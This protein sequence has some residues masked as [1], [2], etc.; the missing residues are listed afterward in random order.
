[1]S[2][3][4]INI[5]RKQA[6]CFAAFLVLYEFLTYIANDMIMPGM[7]RVVHA[8][9]SD[10]SAVATSL[11]A[12]VLGGASLQLLLGPLSDRFGRRPVMLAGAT[13]FLFFTLFIA[14]S[15][16]MNQFL[17]ARFFEGMGLCFIGVIGYATLQEIFAEMDAIRLVAVLSNVATLA[18]LLGPLAGAAC[19]LYFSWRSIFVAI[20]LLA[21]VALIGLWYFMPESVGTT[22]R[23]GQTIPRVPLTP[24]V[25][26][27]NYWQLLTNPSFMIG[28]ISF[29]TINI[30]CIAWIA[31]S[32]IIIITDAQLSVMDYALWQLPLFGAGIMGNWFLHW[33]TKRR[34]LQQIILTGSLILVAGLLLAFICGF[35]QTNFLWLIPGLAIYGFGLGISVGPLSRYV[36]F[37]TNVSKGTAF[38]MISMISM[39]VQALGVEIGKH[40]YL[41]H[42]NSNLS[43]YFALS[44]LVYLLGIATIFRLAASN[45]LSE[46]AGTN[47]GFSSKE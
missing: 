31:L 3:P 43:L 13:L 36:L 1:M 6:L 22:K 23:D 27:G 18:P 5:T 40:V 25:M 29:G 30:T 39:G 42:D 26:F 12:Y 32:P 16:S 24:R 11:T 47:Y 2:Q 37:S 33:L 45:T 7:I 38:A 15:Q 10:E 35:Q 34:T 8:F 19:I 28:A 9:N 20:G 14:A 21:G 44:G 41:N 46:K 4:L 17:V